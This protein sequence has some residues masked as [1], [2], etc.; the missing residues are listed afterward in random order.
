MRDI[1]KRIAA[2]GY[3]V[4]VANPFTA[5]PKVRLHDDTADGVSECGRRR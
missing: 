5:F 1:A 2:E 4:L 3:S